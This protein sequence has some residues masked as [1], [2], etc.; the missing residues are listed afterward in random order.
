MP[1]GTE[2]SRAWCGRQDLGLH[3]EEDLQHVRMFRGRGDAAGATHE[4]M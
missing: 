1:E 2:V 4:L 3:E